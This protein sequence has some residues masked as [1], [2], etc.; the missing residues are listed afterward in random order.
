MCIRDRPA[1][2]HC[3]HRLW[4]RKPAELSMQTGRIDSIE[5]PPAPGHHSK[6]RR[7]EARAAMHCK[8]KCKTASRAPKPGQQAN[9]RA[10]KH[11]NLS[12]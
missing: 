2:E 6:T 3:E 10:P 4:D 7:P 11:P 5:T 1:S 12:S 8:T 9:C